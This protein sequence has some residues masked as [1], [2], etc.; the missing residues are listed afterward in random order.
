MTRLAC[1]AANGGYHGDGTQCA[2]VVCSSCPC[3]FNHDGVVN[4]LDLQLF[5]I[6]YGQGNADINGDGVTNQDDITA[7]LA[8]YNNPGPGCNP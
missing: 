4:D 8:C 1:A 3:D 2:A 6:A 7:F 5:L